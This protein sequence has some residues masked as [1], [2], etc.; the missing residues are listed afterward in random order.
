MI[1]K[2]KKKNYL[3]CLNDFDADQVK[4]AYGLVLCRVG[5]N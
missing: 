5:E 1:N 3:T 4:F 2:E